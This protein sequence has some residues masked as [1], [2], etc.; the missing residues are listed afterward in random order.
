[1]GL[2]RARSDTLDY[3]GA[4]IL[5]RGDNSSDV[6]R[7]NRCRGGRET[8]PGAVMRMMGCL[9]MRSEWCFRVK[10]VKGVANTL[11]DGISR[12]DRDSISPKLTAFR[13][14][15]NW[16][17]QVLGEAEIRLITDVVASSTRRA[18]ESGRRSWDKVC[19][20]MHYE[21]CMKPSDSEEHKKW[22][23]IEYAS[24]CCEAEGNLAGTISRKLAAVQ[25]FHR[26]EAGVKLP[27]T[28]PVLKSALKGITRGHVAA[29][30]PRQVRLS[31]SWGMLLEG[32]GLIPSWGAGGKDMWL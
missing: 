6:H 23:L 30:T 14:D 27:T 4:S 18:C 29:G 3:P 1:M 25:Y 13:P 8:R 10:H 26:L 32:E 28:A 2:K 22:V 31:V 21:K 19:R 20:L 24:W 12:W 15:V 7:V 16:Q 11:T 17:E 5:M 9:E